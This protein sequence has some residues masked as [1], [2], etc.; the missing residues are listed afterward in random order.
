MGQTLGWG[1]PL[2][3]PGRVFLLGQALKHAGDML[4]PNFS[5]WFSWTSHVPCD[6]PFLRQADGGG[7]GISSK[8]L[9][10]MIVC[11]S[12]NK[13]HHIERH[14]RTKTIPG[15]GGGPVGR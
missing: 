2:E 11:R 13:H 1:M 8:G 5:F 12:I 14:A 3:M 9:E 10:E 6:L 4:L 7:Y 15:G